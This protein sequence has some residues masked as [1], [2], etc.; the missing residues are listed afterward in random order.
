MTIPHVTPV[1]HLMQRDLES[2]ADLLAWEAADKSRVREKE[3]QPTYGL[4]F[5]LSHLDII[6]IV[7]SQ[8]SMYRASAVTALSEVNVEQELED[9]FRTELHLRL[10]WGV[11]G[12]GAPRGERVK[13]FDRL[14]T[15]LSEKLEP[16]G[17]DGTEV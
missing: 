1:V 5:L 4:D 8:C 13:K 6:R 3:I 15:A 9:T 10:M 17:D 2:L 7:A 16:P 11:K 12:A 14:L